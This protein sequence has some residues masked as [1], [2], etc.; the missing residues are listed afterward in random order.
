MRVGILTG[1]GDAPG[2]NNVIRGVVTKG[3]NA[4]KYE[5][6]GFKDGWKGPLEGLTR[7]VTLADVA[8]I[9]DEGGTILGS[10]RTNPIKI[11]NGVAR[12]LVYQKLLITIFQTPITHLV[13]KHLWQL[14]LRL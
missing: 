4:Y 1:G 13:F 3:I 8:H 2:L 5:F 12:L 14:Q 11:E 7:P 9:N 6:V 10:S